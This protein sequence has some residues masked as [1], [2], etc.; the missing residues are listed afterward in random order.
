M[1]KKILSSFFCVQVPQ[2]ILEE[3]EREMKTTKCRIVVTQE[4]TNSYY[5]Y[6]KKFII[7]EWRQKNLTYVPKYYCPFSFSNFQYERRR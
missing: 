6:Q 5:F 7:K 4:H 3:H 2:F 1:K